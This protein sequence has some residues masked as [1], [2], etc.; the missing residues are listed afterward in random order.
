MLSVLTVS[1]QTEQNDPDP[2]RFEDQIASFKNWDS[3]NSFPEKAILFTGSSSARMWNTAE[4]FPDYP[5]INRGFGGSH[6]SDVQYFFDDVIAPYNP[7]VIV[8]YAGDND[9][10]AGKSTDQIV[11]DYKRLSEQIISQFPE[12]SL[13][14]VSIKPSSS[15]WSLWPQMMEVNNQIEQYS[16]VN[17]QLFYVDLATPLLTS[18]G[19]P[20]DSLFMDDLLHLNEAGYDRWNDAIAPVLDDIW[21]NRTQ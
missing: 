1:A 19:T 6:I 15:R 14:F 3:K 4:S 16:S 10:A 8:L 5:V 11:D 9:V 20:D 2:L 17:K 13:L 18:D 7:S 12:I 21:N